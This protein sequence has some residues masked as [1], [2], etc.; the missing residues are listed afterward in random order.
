VSRD[1]LGSRKCRH[2]AIAPLCSV[3]SV[4]KT[5]VV[6]TII[7]ATLALLSLALTLWQWAVAFRFPLHQRVAN[8]SWVPAVTVLKPL[9][10]LD[11]E[12]AD[13]LRSW[14][15]QQYSGEVQILFGVASPI[16]PVCELVR[17]LVESHPKADAQLVICP[18]N[19]GAN[20]KVSTL[21]QLMRLA[22]HDVI[23][24]SDADV[25][26]PDG[27]LPQVLAPLR[28]PSLGLVNCFY[29]IA[30]GANLAMRWEAFVVNADFWS[31]VL[32]SQ[33][34]KPLDFALGAVMATTRE[35]LARIGG[36]D[37][38]A[39]YLAD[40]YQLGHC[41]ARTGAR[42][43]LCPLVVECRNAPMSWREVWSHQIRWARTIR[44]CQPLPYFFSQLHNATFWPWLW[45]LWQP[46]GIVFAIAGCCL[47]TR[48]ATG[49]YC[50]QKLTG[51]ADLNSLW[52]APVKDLL[53]TMIWALAFFGRR[54]KWRGQVFD[55]QPGGKLVR[56][57]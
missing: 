48:V 40:D 13:C 16:D 50:E 7:L 44:V 34:L 1:V 2:L 43:A 27:F 5:A 21:I 37:S 10:G 38:L 53:Q 42:I 6:L 26:V 19:F 46:A 12:T 33:S 56:R 52:M 39:A 9:K 17:Q 11:S 14:L 25:W 23:M 20:A 4:L 28:D 57:C 32:Q 35:Q 55:V 30:P 22:R 3:P 31:Q 47:L 36:F 41:I 18:E 15:A 29:R 51:G 8:N 24:V 54:I 45:A 49:F